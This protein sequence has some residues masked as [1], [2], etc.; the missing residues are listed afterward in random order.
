M[1]KQQQ[2]TERLSAIESAIAHLQH[3]LDQLNGVVLEQTGRLTT[4]DESL[5]RLEQRLREHGDED[6]DPR[7][8]GPASR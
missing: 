5:Q 4:L 7:D 6:H 8:E 2:L 1:S 3:D